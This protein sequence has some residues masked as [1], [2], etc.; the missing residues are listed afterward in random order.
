M[1]KKLVLLLAFVLLGAH[2][3]ISNMQGN[4]FAEFPQRMED[5]LGVAYELT[6]KQCGI[7][8]YG[9]GELDEGCKDHSGVIVEVSRILIGQER[10]DD[11][12][13]A[14]ALSL[15][16][17]A[18]K[19]KEIGKTVYD[20]SSNLYP[21]EETYSYMIDKPRIYWRDLRAHFSEK[22]DMLQLVLVTKSALADGHDYSG[23]HDMETVLAYLESVGLIEDSSIRQDIAQ[24]KAVGKLD[25]G[26]DGMKIN[27]IS[28]EA[29]K[30]A[31][32]I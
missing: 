5:T 22:G 12:A 10:L 4:G 19:T 11:D 30:R 8:D 1:H 27:I 18:D 15:A 13:Y 3:N 14:E 26:L 31:W 25:C 20:I 24:M 29:L 6:W 9:T 21:P 28:E 32:S 23:Y 17:F 2:S 7:F 16:G